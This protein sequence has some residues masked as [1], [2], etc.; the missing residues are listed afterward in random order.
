MIATL[1]VDNLGRFCPRDQQAYASSFASLA[2]TLM[3]ALNQD[4]LQCIGEIASISIHHRDF[5]LRLRL[6][7]FQRCVAFQSLGASLLRSLAA[8]ISVLVQGE[9]SPPLEY[10]TSFIPTLAHLVRHY[11]E[12]V[13]LDSLSALYCIASISNDAVALICGA[14]VV[15]R[16]SELHVSQEIAIQVSALRCTTLISQTA[17]HNIESVFDSSFLESI[18]FLLQS[19]CN[20][21][22]KDCCRVLLRTCTRSSQS[23]ASIISNGTFLT[24]L[25]LLN[26]RDAEMALL[27]RSVVKAI[28]D[29]CNNGEILTVAILQNLG[30][31]SDTLAS[32]RSTNILQALET[33]GMFFHA[34]MV[35]CSPSQVASLSQ[36]PGFLDAVQKMELLIG[37]PNEDIKRCTSFIMNN[38]IHFIIGK[39]TM[40]GF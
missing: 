21:L 8:A 28:C 16:L 6:F 12:D 5:I 27:V 9:P 39:C 30:F 40:A 34:G 23:A 32:H 26:D 20:G 25:Y 31:F 29:A 4:S 22:K 13:I 18:H 15:S 14:G 33:I 35:L 1:V 10:V 2:Q 24:L 11:D 38:Y 37:H 17:D 19:S 7:D 3:I 36:S